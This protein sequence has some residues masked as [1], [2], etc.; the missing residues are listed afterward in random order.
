MTTTI[1]SPISGKIV[2]RN[3]AVL[4]D[5]L[6][7]NRD[8]HGAGRLAAERRARPHRTLRLLRVARDLTQHT[9]RLTAAPRRATRAPSRTSRA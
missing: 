6:A 7:V 5:P 3:G 1:A 2:A 8:P 4:A 9:A